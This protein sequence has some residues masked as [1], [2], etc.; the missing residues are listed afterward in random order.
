MIKRRSQI[1][2]CLF[3][4]S[5]LVLTSA[6]WLGAYYIRCLSGWMPLE[7]D[8]P[9]LYL[10]LRQ[11]PLL[12]VLTA[13]SYRMVGQYEVNRLRRFREEMVTV[14]KGTA[15]LVLLVLATLFFQHDPYE[16][17][18]IIVLFSCLNMLGVLA[19][20]RLAWGLI[21]FLRSRGFNQKFALIVGTGRV[22]RKTARALRR[23]SWLGIKNVGFIDEQKTKLSSDLDVLGGFAELPEVIKRY[24][25][26]HVFIALPMN[27][28]DDARKVYGLLSQSVVDVRLVADV[29]NLAGLSLTTSNLDGLPLIGLRES[30]HYGINVV[31][32]RIMDVAVSLLALILLSPILFL[33]GIAVKLTSPGPILY[34]QE[35]CSL[36]GK[37]FH[38]LKFRSLR[39]DAEKQTGAVWAQK[40]DNR[41]TWFGAFLRKTS[42]DEL[43][44]LINV[45]LGDM[46]LVGPRPERP[47]FIQQFSKTIPNYMVRHCVKAGITGWAQVHGWR[48]NTSLRKRLQFD[49]YYITHWN[50]WLDIRIMWMTLFHGLVHRNAY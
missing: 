20:R 8:V 40:N 16:S 38:M 6:A 14:I 27:R 10:C 13:L 29:P 9:E 43:P 31:V 17:R 22:A 39:V 7:T 50:P 47:V 41:R 37:A 3:L 25:I 34:R 32:K 30:P 49:L 35:R 48:G 46:S 1:L 19:G 24:Q 11:L 36:N 42:L 33:I 2:C 21:R 44:Q 15:L 5:D 4:A 45:L 12:W 18:A 26:Q 28:Y 23:T